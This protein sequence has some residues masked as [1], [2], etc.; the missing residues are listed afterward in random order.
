M[1]F[2]DYEKAFENFRDIRKYMP[3]KQWQKASYYFNLYWT[4]RKSN[5]VDNC[6]TKKFAKQR[7]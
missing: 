5:G 6:V 7:C 2:I 1:C 3:G 4:Q